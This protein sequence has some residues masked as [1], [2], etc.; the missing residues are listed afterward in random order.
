MTGK[1]HRYPSIRYRYFGNSAN[2]TFNWNVGA[3]QH[4]N[5]VRHL[6]VTC[7]VILCKVNRIP[8]A[9]TT[10]IKTRTYALLKENC[11]FDRQQINNKLD[12]VFNNK[13]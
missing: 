1:L 10:T 13:Y 8:R 12:N 9:K 3:A 6:A 7:K 2:Q 11:T 5:V 4:N